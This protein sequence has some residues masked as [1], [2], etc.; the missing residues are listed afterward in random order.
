MYEKS[1][2]DYEQEW[3]DAV[4]EGHIVSSLEE[5]IEDCKSGVYDDWNIWNHYVS[6]DGAKSNI[7]GG[8]NLANFSIKKRL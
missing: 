1:K 3:R 6:S 5:Y 7:I 8:F 4:A 2:R